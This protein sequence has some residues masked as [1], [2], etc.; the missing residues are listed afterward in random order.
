MS[1]H[2]YK[3]ITRQLTSYIRSS[4]RNSGYI[5]IYNLLA[6]NLLF[7]ELSG[8]TEGFRETDLEVFFPELLLLPKSSLRL[9][10]KHKGFTYGCFDSFFFLSRFCFL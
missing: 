2:L 10:S 4:D 8:F 7:T 9:Q 3:S 5:E 6:N 1:N